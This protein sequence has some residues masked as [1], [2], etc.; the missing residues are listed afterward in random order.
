MA[1]LALRSVKSRAN[2]LIKLSFFTSVPLFL[3]IQFCPHPRWIDILFLRVMY[4]RGCFVSIFFSFFLGLSCTDF[5]TLG[6][7]H[8]S[9]HEKRVFSA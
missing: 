6:P 8:T 1:L 7:N 3:Q 9:T 2:I 5:A 4:H